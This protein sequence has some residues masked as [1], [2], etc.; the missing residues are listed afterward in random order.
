MGGCVGITSAPESPRLPA[1]KACQTKT[2]EGSLWDAGWGEHPRPRTLLGKSTGTDQ[3][4]AFSVCFKR[5]ASPLLEF[6]WLTSCM[7]PIVHHGTGVSPLVGSEGARSVCGHQEHTHTGSSDI[8]WLDKQEGPCGG[9]GQGQ[10][11]FSFFSF[12][13][14]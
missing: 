14:L 2:R 6:H 12:S 11:Y 13:K 8:K 10:L 7:W 5:R 1:T 3:P 4:L 9:V